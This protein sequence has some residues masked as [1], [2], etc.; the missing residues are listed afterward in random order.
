M[1]RDLFVLFC[2]VY[3]WFVTWKYWN[4]IL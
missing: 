3:L 4:W 1:R 2:D